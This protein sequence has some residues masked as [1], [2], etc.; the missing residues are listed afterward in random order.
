M[1]IYR[2]EIDMLLTLRQQIAQE[3]RETEQLLSARLEDILNTKNNND[4]KD[5]LSGNGVINNVRDII[6]A[7]V[8]QILVDRSR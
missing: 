3:L 6:I 8:L 5:D 4:D 2:D 7:I 1:F